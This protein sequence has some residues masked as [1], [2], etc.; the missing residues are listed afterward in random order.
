MCNEN[1]VRK[2]KANSVDTRQGPRVTIPWRL[3]RE[4]SCL[5]LHL[6]QGMEHNLAYTSK[7]RGHMTDR[8]NTK[9]IALLRS[10]GALNSYAVKVAHNLF[11][12]NEFF[13]PHDMVQVKYE[14]LRWV[15]SHEGSVKEAARIFGLSRQAFYQ[16]QASFEQRGIAGLIP[17]KRGPRGR[18]KLTQE[19]LTFVQ[20]KMAQNRSL[21][22]SEIVE[23]IK[24]QFNV[25]VHER[26]VFRALHAIQSKTVQKKK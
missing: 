12:E 18:S 19:I 17:K 26:S 23:M 14:M 3:R 20:E 13:D 16:A 4:I 24:H 22:T 10:L 9:K 1:Y 8:K 5:L 11:L 6:I 21:S 2:C 15:R 7:H 25:S